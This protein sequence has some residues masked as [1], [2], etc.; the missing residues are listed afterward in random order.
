MDLQLWHA[1]IK[2]ILYSDCYVICC[3]HTYIHSVYSLHCMC[4]RWPITT[5]IL[6]LL[7]SPI[8]S[9]NYLSL[10]QLWLLFYCVY[11]NP[12]CQLSLLE[13]TGAPKENQRF[14]AERWLT[15]FTWVRS[16]NRSHELRGERCLLWRMRN[17]RPC[18]TRNL[19]WME[20][21]IVSFNTFQ[22]AIHN[23][24]KMSAQWPGAQFVRNYAW[25]ALNL[26]KA[27]CQ[28]K[29]V[30]FCRTHKQIEVVNPS[31]RAARIELKNAVFYQFPYLYIS[32]QQH[33]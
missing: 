25:L 16:E 24:S 13:K 7:I 10:Q 29:V 26:D 21:A 31:V 8:L 5:S 1:L 12:P 33:S 15:L 22:M 23:R 9:L 32:S 30:H 4:F 19:N 17:R 28:K 6:R 11:P 3:I 20:I 18:C 27:L 2:L 14:S